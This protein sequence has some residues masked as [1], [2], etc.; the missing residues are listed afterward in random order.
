VTLTFKLLCPKVNRDHLLAL[1]IHDTKRVNLSEISLKV[2][3]GQDVANAGLTDERTDR[4]TDG[5]I[6]G[7]HA[8]N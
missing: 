1:A 2:I 8:P 7:R 4:R 6:V 3:S 5:H